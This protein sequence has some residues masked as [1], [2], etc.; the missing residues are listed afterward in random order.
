[1]DHS[2]P[3]FN[4]T[5]L[6]NTQQIY[7]ER[8]Q[9]ISLKP[10]AE[11]KIMVCAH[12]KLDENSLTTDTSVTKSKNTILITCKKSGGTSSSNSSSSSGNTT[13]SASNTSANTTSAIDTSS[14]SSNTSSIMMND[15]L[16]S[17]NTT[18]NNNNNSSNTMNVVASIKAIAHTCTSIIE[19]SPSNIKFGDST[20]GDI[21][22]ASVTIYNRSDLATRIS[23]QFTSKVITCKTKS[24]IISPHKFI[25]IT[26]RLSPRRVNPNY[27]KQ[28]T[29]VNE[30]NKLNEQ[31][32]EVES[33][34]IDRN[35]LNFHC[36]YYDVHTTSQHNFAKSINFG[37]VALNGISLSK[38]QI[39]NISDE[40]ITLKF[41]SSSPNEIST[42]KVKRTTTITNQDYSSGGGGGGSQS[43][44][45][46]LISSNV[47]QHHHF[48]ED[49]TISPHSST[50]TTNNRQF[51]DDSSM[52]ESEQQFKSTPPPL[53]KRR[54]KKVK[55]I[56]TS[57][58]QRVSSQSNLT[59]LSSLSTITTTSNN[60][61]STN[62]TGV[63]SVLTPKSPY[64]K[65]L[66]DESSNT[67]KRSTSMDDKFISQLN[68][69]T[70]LEYLQS[71]MTQPNVSKLNIHHFEGID[72][73]KTP[74]S[75][76]DSDETSDG[77][78]DNLMIDDSEYSSVTDELFTEQVN[79][80]EYCDQLVSTYE[81]I[82]ESLFDTTQNVDEE[83]II[84]DELEFKKKLSNS[85]DD[86]KF[87]IP[88]DTI[89]IGP[90]S[91]TEIYI[92]YRPK[93]TNSKFTSINLNNS[94]PLSL[95]SDFSF[96]NISTNTTTSISSTTTTGSSNINTNNTNNNNTNSMNA[97]KKNFEKLFI[98]LIDYDT[99]NEQTDFTLPPRELTIQSKICQSMME[100]AQ[101]NINFGSITNV[102]DRKKT[103]TISNGSEVPLLFRIKR[104]G[105]IASNDI[106]ILDMLDDSLNLSWCG[107]VRPYG[108]RDIQLYFKPSLPGVFNE[109]LTFENV[110]D[111]SDSINI[112]VKADIRNYE[113]FTLK[114]ND[115]NFGNILLNQF[116]LSKK[117]VV[118]NMSKNRRIFETQID[119]CSFSFCKFEFEYEL[120]QVSQSTEIEKLEAELEKLEHKY[121]ICVRK[122]KSSKIKKLTER[123]NEIKKE[124]NFDDYTPTIATTITGNSTTN[125][126]EDSLFV[127]E[128]DDEGKKQRKFKKIEEN[129]IRFSI[130][131]RMSQVINL[132]IKPL[133]I[134][135][136]NIAFE[137]GI[138]RM[139]VYENRNTDEQKMVT[140]SS[141]VHF[142]I[143]S[144]Q[145]FTQ[146]SGSS[147]ST[148]SNVSTPLTPLYSSSYYYHWYY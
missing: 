100:I 26:F 88:C 108:S 48:D 68:D 72:E 102:E 61:A 106:K 50:T 128:S 12:V 138:C 127:S 94:S 46:N 73:L 56:V 146:N 126:I 132:K 58:L 97:I 81:K 140:L 57:N 76:Y 2:N 103:I 82:Q 52:N 85:I 145:N 34:N 112:I 84:R 4:S 143:K 86:L 109:T 95:Y 141:I 22:F 49:D 134:E 43:D 113:K 67:L 30:S 29:I 91:S 107:L 70:N 75:I 62:N 148:G 41:K 32:I 7:R 64:L 69:P 110:L 118:T 79:P 92:T 36:K 31:I 47:H 144:F 16:L 89:S 139:L 93:S 117:I 38:F 21:K 136:P 55:Q 6:P 1:M 121:R 116:S 27:R 78:D 51:T 115:I 3:H 11:R 123:I 9:E 25:R 42:F 119:Y 14:A 10:K 28:I 87:L 74:L 137:N 40:P 120:E 24:A 90:T 45:Y 99:N 17:T 60:S 59:P 63:S 124:L 5:C 135:T 129:G 98:E 66:K 44:H 35:M 104:S 33:N 19:V 65:K 147:S 125:N 77:S 8:I 105:S 71:I 96:N 15:Q 142:D 101:K 83:M 130:P 13:N 23:V 122:N 133:L 114:S 80:Q 53:H 37:V 20:I 111:E 54:K 39:S 131:P 18:S